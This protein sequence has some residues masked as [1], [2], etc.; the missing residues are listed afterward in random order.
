LLEYR[1]FYEFF[2]RK[3]KEKEQFDEK[4]VPNFTNQF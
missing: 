3:M 2:D 1:G 4:K